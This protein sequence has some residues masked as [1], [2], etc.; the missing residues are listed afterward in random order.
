[1]KTQ[2]QILVVDDET[3]VR[4]A[5]R[6]LLAE[7]N[8]AV[9]EAN[10]GAEA[11]GLFKKGRFDLVLTDLNMPHVMGDELAVHIRQ[12]APGQPILMLTAHAKRP[13]PDNPVNAVIRKPFGLRELRETMARLLSAPGA[14]LAR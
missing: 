6:L 10:N 2:K 8:H 9:V 1:M 11:L 14:A 5:L 7:D 13:G 4:E 12:L 3:H